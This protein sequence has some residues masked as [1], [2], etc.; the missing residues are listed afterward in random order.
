M[1]P[2]SPRLVAQ[3]REPPEVAEADTAAYASE[4]ELQLAAPRRAPGLH[5]LVVSNEAGVSR[6][7]ISIGDDR[8]HDAS[9]GG[10]QWWA[11]GHHHGTTIAG[12][13]V[14]G[15]RYVKTQYRLL[16]G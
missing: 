8:I 16:N 13:G 14:A 7:G 6:V 3:V 10:V 2:T 5:V 11:G 12:P 9:G 4:N 1:V 15:L